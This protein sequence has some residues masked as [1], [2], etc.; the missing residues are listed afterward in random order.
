MRTCYADPCKRLCS[1]RASQFHNWTDAFPCFQYQSTFRYQIDTH[2]R[3]RT[4]W[5]EGK[6]GTL[7]TMAAIAAVVSC[8]GTIISN[9]VLR[10][11][12]ISG[13]INTTFTLFL[14]YRTSRH[15][16]IDNNSCC[17]AACTVQHINRFQIDFTRPFFLFP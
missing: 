4:G 14:S 12:L 3:V 15:S 2:S 6:I 7:S 9:A 11:C 16:F 13:T 10:L 17:A 5:K 8:P 1:H